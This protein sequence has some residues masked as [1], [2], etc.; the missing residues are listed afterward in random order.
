VRLVGCSV[1]RTEVVHV[2]GSHAEVDWPPAGLHVSEV[3]S[4]AAI[5]EALDGATGAG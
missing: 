2:L 5:S 1:F 3:R 4:G